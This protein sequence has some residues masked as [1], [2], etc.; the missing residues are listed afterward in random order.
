MLKADCEK[1]FAPGEAVSIVL[2]DDDKANY[3]IKNRRTIARFIAKYL[4][5]RELP[6]T[7][8][9]FHR[10]GEGD[11]FFIENPRKTRAAR[12]SRR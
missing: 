1:G 7:L 10:D 3:G 11:F 6:Y 5:D 4:S 2:N 12:P 8:K 9:S